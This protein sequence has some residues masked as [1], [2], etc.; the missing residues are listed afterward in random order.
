MDGS[1]PAG[2]RVPGSAGLLARVL[3][4]AMEQPDTSDDIRVRILD[5][6]RDQFSTIG[7][8]HSTMDDV[9][10]R[11][12]VARITV[13]RRFP[14]KDALVEEVTL[15]E[16]RDYFDQF[17]VDIREA[18]TVA[19]RVVVGF[20]S[21][22]S[23]MRR[24]PLLRGLLAVEADLLTSSMIGDGG[25]MVAVVRQF[26]AGQLRQEQLAGNISG[27]VDTDVVAEMMVRVTASFLAIPSR[28]IDTD[29]DA[30]MAD[31]ARWV[32]VPLL[33]ARATD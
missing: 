8:R 4:E 19:D 30:Q 5:A 21:S 33:N 1:V 23:V 11:A 6:A 12:R 25:H 13:Y 27:D 24:N 3:T 29:D 31:V 9:A 17:L 18:T 7:I 16:F 10:R 14:T 26:V 22:L 28:V 32:L 15:R 20:V 2:E